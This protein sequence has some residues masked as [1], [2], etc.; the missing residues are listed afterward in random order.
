MEIKQ[1]KTNNIEECWNFLFNSQGKQIDSAITA[2]EVIIYVGTVRCLVTFINETALGCNLPKDQPSAGDFKGQDKG[3]GLPVVWV[4]LKTN[5]SCFT[6]ETSIWPEHLREQVGLQTIL[7]NQI[8]P[9]PTLELPLMC[10]LF[11]FSLQV[12]HGNLEFRIGYIFYPPVV[13]IELPLISGAV[14]VCILIVALCFLAQLYGSKREAKPIQ[15]DM[16]VFNKK[17]TF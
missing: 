13:P 1:P 3:R 9:K 8:K 6:W 14:L 7:E 5:L 15:E 10:N 16:R 12:I 11:L 17:P 4:S 2:K